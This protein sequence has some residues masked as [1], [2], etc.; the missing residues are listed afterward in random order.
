MTYQKMTGSEDLISRDFDTLGLSYFSYGLIVKNHILTSYFSNK[1][2]GELYKARRYNLIDPL[3]KSVLNSHIP[4]IVWDAFHSTGKENYI[5]NERQELCKVQ[6]GLTLGLR[7]PESTEII[8]LGSNVS[9]K[10]FYE[11]L[12]KEN[13]LATIYELIKRF[14]LTHKES[15]FKIYH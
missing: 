14:Y 3:L 13:Y 9:T 11:L 7:T 5:M 2:W 12:N 1:E 4:L 10:E 6:S 15:S 8:A